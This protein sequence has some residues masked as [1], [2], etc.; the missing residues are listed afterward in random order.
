M[1]K[2]LLS[3]TLVAALAG[4]PKAEAHPALLIPI[5]IAM[6]HGGVSAAWMA[7]AAGAGGLLIG[8]WLGWFHPWTTPAVAEPLPPQPVDVPLPPVRHYRHHHCN[9]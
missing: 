1:K 8:S 2:I 4:A 9:C 5:G 3:C 6:M 7:G